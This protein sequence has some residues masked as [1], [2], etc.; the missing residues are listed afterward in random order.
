MSHPLQLESS[1]EALFST[2]GVISSITVCDISAPIR[3]KDE[4]VAFSFCLFYFCLVN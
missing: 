2:T 4:A 1:N 3:L